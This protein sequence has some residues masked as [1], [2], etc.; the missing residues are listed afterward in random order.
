MTA[1]TD[2]VTTQLS[3]KIGVGLREAMAPK[4]WAQNFE[5]NPWKISVLRSTTNKI[6]P[7]DPGSIIPTSGY[8]ML[9]YKLLLKK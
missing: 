8:V 5:S 3:Y 6:K 2:M 1:D 9:D 4:S 7:E